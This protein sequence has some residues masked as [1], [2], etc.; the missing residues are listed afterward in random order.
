MSATD[1]PVFVCRVI[2]CISLLWLL[3]LLE[4]YIFQR[5]IVRKLLAIHLQSDLFLQL[6]C[7][8]ATANTQFAFLA[9]HA[10]ICRMLAL[11][12]SYPTIL[13]NN[14]CLRRFL[15]MLLEVT[16]QV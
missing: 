13:K 7:L 14:G 10:L 12:I 9:H 8:A 11:I 3:G 4:C 5:M 2:V 16:A 15:I 6:K 1:L